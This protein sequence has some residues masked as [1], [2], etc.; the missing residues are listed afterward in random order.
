REPIVSPAGRGRPW[1]LP[2]L[3]A[4]FVLVA[5]AEV[6]LLML[7]G[8]KIGV[9]P[10]FV[11]LV[12]E[13]IL[14]AWLMRREGTKVWSA[15]AQAFNTGRLPT[16]ELAD[17][18][19]VLLG[20][21]ML[22]LPGFFTD[23]LGLIFLLPLTR[24]LARKSLGFLLARQAARSGVDPVSIRTNF[25]TGTVIRGETVPDDATEPPAEPRDVVIRG[26]V[27]P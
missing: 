20:G 1:V 21:C 8:S 3:V 24:P 17:A 23:V 12:C 9:L 22:I 15:L 11:I 27:E 25:G 19:L 5:I 16:G 14:G 2:T 4:A 7:V 26:E 10:T 18:A 13:A 6:W